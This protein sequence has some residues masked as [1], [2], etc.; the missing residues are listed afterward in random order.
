VGTTF[1]Y[2][3]PEIKEETFNPMKKRN[4]FV[5]LTAVLA[6]TICSA[7]GGF[8]TVSVSAGATRKTLVNDDFTGDK[9]DVE[10]WLYYDSGIDLAYD[11][12][13]VKVKNGRKSKLR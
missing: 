12:N 9:I 4:V 10:K 5:V 7:A 6:V 11:K 2:R 3:R 1:E 8:G 13:V